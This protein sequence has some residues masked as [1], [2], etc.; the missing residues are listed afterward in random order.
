[1]KKLFK[2]AQQIVQFFG[3]SA[4]IYLELFWT[5]L[6]A[7][8]GYLCIG[9]LSKTVLETSLRT[10]LLFHIWGLFYIVAK[11]PYTRIRR[12]KDRQQMKK[13]NKL[14]MLVSQLDSGELSE[15]V[16]MMVG[17]LTRD[18]RVTLLQILG[19]LVQEK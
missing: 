12:W 15:Q 4:T 2:A 14:Q 5:I 17:H 7:I 9:L 16:Q 11:Q 10:F 18:D 6:L 13:I 1:M 3:T 19:R 8:L